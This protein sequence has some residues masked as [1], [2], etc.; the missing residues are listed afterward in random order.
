MEMSLVGDTHLLFI[1]AASTGPVVSESCLHKRES[2]QL[3]D[4]YAFLFN[5]L[6]GLYKNLFL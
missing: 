3:K 5:R 6:I 4:E 2:L 1:V